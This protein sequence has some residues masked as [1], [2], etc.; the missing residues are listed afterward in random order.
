MTTAEIHERTELERIES[1]RRERLRGAGF[2]AEA[3]EKLAGHHE[4]DI[5][6]AIELVERGCPPDVAV[7]ILV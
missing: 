4:V 3:A 5:H 2:S 7:R 6:H 1:W